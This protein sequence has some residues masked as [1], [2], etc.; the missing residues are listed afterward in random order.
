M[1]LNI[2]GL[3]LDIAWRDKEA[4]LAALAEA[5]TRMPQ[6]VDIV[7]LPE[8]FSTGFVTD[9]R[10]AAINLAERNIDSTVTAL[11]RLSAQY[12]VAIAGTF[13]A[14]TLAKVFNRAFFIE[15][16]G[17]DTY[18]DKR[19]LFT[20]GGEAR[21]YN[22]GESFPPII[23]YRG[24]NIMPLICYDLRFPGF[25]RNINR[26]YDLLLVMANWPR[27][28]INAWRTL[29]AA[30]AIENQCFVVGINRSGT[31]AAGLEYPVG[32]SFVFDYLG[33]SIGNPY[34]TI[35]IAAQCDEAAYH[36]HLE[37]FPAWRDADELTL[38]D[39]DILAP[40]ARKQQE[41]P[42]EH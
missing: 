3:S 9:D 11:K 24:W 5:M 20:P 28:R 26:R 34:G 30:R 15:P 14:R 12:N 33:N 19:H 39:R 21:C 8:M 37:R 16:S 38:I 27:Q 17:D 1:N 10:D 25:C 29:L 41:R 4:N 35:G 32:S 42:A 7:V 31:D 22:R 13:I 36:R 6:G 18:Y 40:A 2:Y 23:R